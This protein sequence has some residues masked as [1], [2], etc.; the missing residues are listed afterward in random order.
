M[1]WL[2]WLSMA[3]A[4]VSADTIPHLARLFSDYLGVMLQR[5][6]YFVAN[7]KTQAFAA[8]ISECEAALRQAPIK[9]IGLYRSL[10]SKILDGYS[11]HIAEHPT[12][13]QAE[14]IVLQNLYDPLRDKLRLEELRDFIQH[15]VGE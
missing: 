2:Y 11:D 8:L 15:C 12:V 5:Q 14:E 9:H 7:L 10:C 1:E 13:T 4:A 3:L 6:Y